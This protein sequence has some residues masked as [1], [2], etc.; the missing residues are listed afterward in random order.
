MCYKDKRFDYISN[1]YAFHHFL[2]KE[3]ALDEIYRVL[4]KNGIYKQH[5][6]AIHDMKNG[7]YIITFQQHMMR[8]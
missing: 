8:M 2:N 1:N 5:N 3:A 4:K 7:G 6:I